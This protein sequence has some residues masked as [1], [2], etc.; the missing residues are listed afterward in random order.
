[1]TAR[2]KIESTPVSLEHV[3]FENT[4]VRDL[5]PDPVLTNVPRPVSEASYTRVN[6]TG[7]DAEI[8]GGSKTLPGM[9]PYAA[10]Y[11]G[12]QFGHWAGQLG[13][14]RA[15]TLGE[16]IATDGRRQELQLKGA[17]K[18]PYS[19][20]ADGRAVLRSSLREFLCSEAMHHLGVPTTR[21]LSLVGTGEPVIR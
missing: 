2:P 6:P 9:H 4:Y 17:G 20:T 16:I 14:G 7:V 1:M 5:P 18:T 15:I 19:R 12:H 13:D 21:A 10:R 8:L 11:G 3:A